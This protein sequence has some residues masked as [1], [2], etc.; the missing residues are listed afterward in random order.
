MSVF[1]PVTFEWKG[2]DYTIP[3]DKVL[4]IIADV[5]SIITF[6]ELAAALDSGTKVPLATLSMVYGMVLRYA[7]ADVSDDECYEAMFGDTG[8]NSNMA[9]AMQTLVYMMMPPGV[10]KKLQAAEA[11]D[12]DAPSGPKKT[13]ASSNR[14]SRRS[15]GKRSL[16][17]KSSGS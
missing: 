16:R 17:Q 1:Q 4:P 7:G 5:E 11:V 3:A 15:V 8:Q 9:M 6:V 14:A 10:L 2:D 12:G 13:S